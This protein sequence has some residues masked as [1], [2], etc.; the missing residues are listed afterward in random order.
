MWLQ[1]VVIWLLICCTGLI[2]FN[3]WTGRK[4]LELGES[5]K[6]AKKSLE[7]KEQEVSKADEEL[8]KKKDKIDTLTDMIV[9]Q[10]RTLKYDTA[11]I[12]RQQNGLFNR[13]L[14]MQIS[15]WG[16]EKDPRKF[17]FQL[18]VKNIYEY[19]VY[20]QK[21]AQVYSIKHPK[22]KSIYNWKTGLV[23]IWAESFFE[24]NP[25]QNS[26]SA[27]GGTQ[28]LEYL[29]YNTPEQEKY[30]YPIMVSLGYKKDT[31]QDTISYF[32][33]NISVQVDCMFR[34]LTSKMRDQHGDATSAIVAYNWAYVDP[35][36]SP[37]WASYLE[38]E[39]FLDTCI[40]N[41]KKKLGMK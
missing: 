12:I 16:V 36:Q 1:K 40:E 11:L 6:S 13:E 8:R 7:L 25:V 27:L 15:A 24:K 18:S 29:K 34:I 19:I 39:G 3:F 31:Y 28:V 2:C 32:R 22:Y 41:T 5:L 4:S 9:K 26:F 38:K 21:Y 10:N 17:L 20:C 14:A 35:L 30:L 33:N 37:Y 23:I